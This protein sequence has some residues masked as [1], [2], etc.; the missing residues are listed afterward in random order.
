MKKDNIKSE[1]NIIG[2]K[3]S[4]NGDISSL[5]DLRVDG[6][7]IGNV[8]TKLKVVI[9]LK[10]QIDGN[11]DGTSAD[12]SGKVTGDINIK[13]VL[14]LSATAVIDG[15]INSNKIIIESGAQINGRC[16]IG[17]NSGN[18]HEDNLQSNA[19]AKGE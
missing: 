10:S 12:I 13:E 15:N 2:E 3:T 7:I 17:V 19:E 14:S 11:V 1:L 9:G 4:I 18:N 16:N 8:S 5:G 6:K